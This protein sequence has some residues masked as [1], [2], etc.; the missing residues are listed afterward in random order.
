MRATLRFSGLI[1]AAEHDVVH[2]SRIERRI[3]LHHVGDDERAEVVGARVAQRATEI[4]DG[5]SHT[6]D[7]IGWLGHVCSEKNGFSVS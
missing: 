4:P 3:P 6:V 2:A 5:R 1:R 7:E